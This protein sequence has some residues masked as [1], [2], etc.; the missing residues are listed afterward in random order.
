MFLLFKRFTKRALFAA[1]FLVAL[2]SSS[3]A[4]AGGGD[5]A[6]GGDTGGGDTGGT[7]ADVRPDLRVMGYNIMQLP[8]Q[9]WDQSQR[10]A[11]LPDAIR[12]L[13]DQPDVIAF[14]EVLTDEAL[15]AVQELNDVYPYMTPVLGLVCSGGGWD[16]ISGN[17]SNAFTVVRGGVMVISKYPIIEQHAHVFNASQFGTADYQANKGAVYVEIEKEGHRYHIAGTHTQATHDED[18]AQTAHETRVAQAQEIRDW[19]DGFN[20]PADEPVIVAGDLNVEHDNTSNLNEIVNQSLNATLWFD[21]GNVTDYVHSYPENNWMSRAYNYYF[22]YDM[23]YNKTLDYVVT[24]NGYLQP[25]EPAQQDVI[26]LKATESWYWSY[27]DGRWDLCNGTVWHDGYT[28]DL[29]DHYPV[30]ATYR[31]SNP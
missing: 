26:Q 19:L 11:H 14:S 1:T 15:Y 29:S 9:D 6:D 4:F 20:I 16:S 22:G 13:A 3:M 7:P 21:N 2:L 31:Y 5:P 18:T 17:C 24:L 27:L 8:V 23:C 10:A 12:A 30:V 25:I 28:T